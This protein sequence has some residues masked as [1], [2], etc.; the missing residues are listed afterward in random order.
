MPPQLTK[1][2]SEDAVCALVSMHC[3][4]ASLDPPVLRS[5]DIWNDCE[6]DELSYA[7]KLTAPIRHPISESPIVRADLAIFMLKIISHVLGTQLS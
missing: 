6:K 7:M 2:M 1:K 3:A 5:C 4:S